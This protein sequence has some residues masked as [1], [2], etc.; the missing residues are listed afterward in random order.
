MKPFVRRARR[1][2]LLEPLSRMEALSQRRRPGTHKSRVRAKDQHPVRPQRQVHGWAATSMGGP[3]EPVPATAPATEFSAA[4]AM[5]HVTQ[6]AQQPHPVG[7]ADHARIR[8]YVTAS[9]EGIGLKVER[10]KA[11]AIRSVAGGASAASVE[12][13]LVRVKGTGSTGAVLLVSHYDSVPAA[14]G[15]ADD[16]SGVA[17][18]LETLRAFRASGPLRNDVIA[19][20]TD[21]EE[22]RT[23]LSV[24]A[25]AWPP[26]KP[27]SP[28]TPLTAPQ[29]RVLILL[30]A[31]I[32]AWCTEPL[33]H[34]DPA[35]V[36]LLGAL[37][38]VTPR[39][40]LVS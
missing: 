8:E 39:F 27:E 18:M 5:V 35:I 38:A 29:R 22:R 40:G 6:I 9:L 31:V 19:L 1:L 14:P 3:P 20:F 16:G 23:P 36:A 24:P 12:N 25:D 13:L 11:T 17:A 2:Q 32:I 7:S 34:I 28:G 26:G 4:R 30:G 15:A 37:V 10:Q 21:A 33:H